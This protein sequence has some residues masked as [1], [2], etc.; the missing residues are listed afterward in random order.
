[1]VDGSV[2]ASNIALAEEIALYRGIV[3]SKPL[4]INLIKV[5]RFQDE[6]ADNT[7]SWRSLGVCADVTKHDI[8]R[9]ADRRGAGLC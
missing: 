3:G 6:T 8:L 5:I 2:V 4:P 9:G 7:S 1:V